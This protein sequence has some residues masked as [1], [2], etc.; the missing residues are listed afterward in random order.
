MQRSAAQP[1]Q[2]KTTC[3]GTVPTCLLYAARESRLVLSRL[4]SSCVHAGQ[5]KRARGR[6]YVAAAAVEVDEVDEVE[7]EYT[8]P[9]MQ[10][11]GVRTTHKPFK[12]G[13]HTSTHAVY[14]KKKDR[15]NV[16]HS[17]R[18]NSYL[19]HTQP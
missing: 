17:I 18:L 16:V 11:S 5:A 4:V 1:S 19:I 2:H 8:R 3:L 10:V 15:A 13:K 12:K 7:R 6:G 9:S 14:K